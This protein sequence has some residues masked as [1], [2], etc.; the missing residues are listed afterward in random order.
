M[1]SSSRHRGYVMVNGPHHAL[2][3]RPRIA[4]ARR[5]QECLSGRRTPKKIEPAVE[6]TAAPKVGT[7]T[8]FIAELIYEEDSL[9]SFFSWFSILLGGGGGPGLAGPRHRGNLAGRGGTSPSIC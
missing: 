1:P 9:G 5:D 3:Q 2:R 7:M 6:A 8:D 4:G